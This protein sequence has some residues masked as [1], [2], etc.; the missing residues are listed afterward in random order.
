MTGAP[1]ICA[2]QRDVLSAADVPTQN[3]KQSSRRKNRCADGAESARLS[4]ADEA[5]LDRR[6][7]G[8]RLYQTEK[9][10]EH[11]EPLLGSPVVSCWQ[12]PGHPARAQGPQGQP[13]PGPA[14][15]RGCH[16]QQACRHPGHPARRGNEYSLSDM[17]TLQ[18]RVSQSQ[19]GTA[20]SWKQLQTRPLGKQ[21]AC[22]P[23]RTGPRDG[24]MRHALAPMQRGPPPAAT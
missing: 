20:R 19:H 7:E 18:A 15:R 1:E 3:I 5:A 13:G 12:Q 2:R 11:D 24:I 22:R 17:Q 8:I 9:E 6:V 4:D 10:S 21:A 14:S 16:G 23:L